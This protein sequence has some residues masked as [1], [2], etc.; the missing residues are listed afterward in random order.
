[1][2]NLF[3]FLI[4]CVSFASCEKKEKKQSPRCLYDCTV[5]AEACAKAVRNEKSF[6]S[7]KQ[8]PYLTLLW[9]NH[10]YEDGKESLRIITEKYPGLVEKLEAFRHVDRIGSP[11]T[12]AYGKNGDF[13]PS[14]LRLIAMTGD[15][16]EKVGGLEGA[17][18]IQIGAGFG[19]W[20]QILSAMYRFE[21]Y[22][23]VDL[24]EQ[25]ALAEKC[26][27]EMGVKHVKLLTPEEL[28]K[29]SKYDLCISDLSFS[30]FDP[31]HQKLFIDRAIARSSRGYIL[32]HEFP[33]HY[34][35]APMNLE[36]LKERL[37]APGQPVKQYAH[38]SSH[39]FIY[40]R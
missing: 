22:T 36:R 19:S 14:T 3:V 10:T 32:G 38:D 35:V 16:H 2:K 33:K 20:C 8:D 25:L 34:G 30:E 4:L 29:E 31:V 24:P 37:H 17:H 5:F 1:M 39:Y 11:R 26:L 12:Y 21:S 28:A 27:N 6:A 23:I 7:F 15:L 18:V 9:E 13:S 40:W